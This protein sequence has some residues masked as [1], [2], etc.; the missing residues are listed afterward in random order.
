MLLK[1]YPIN[2]RNA[3]YLGKYLSQYYTYVFKSCLLAFS[4]S[5]G[6]I[7]NSELNELFYWYIV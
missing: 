2:K 7:N 3:I 5:Y 4:Y 1:F 6:S